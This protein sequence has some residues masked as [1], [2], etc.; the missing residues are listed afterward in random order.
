MSLPLQ[1]TKTLGSATKEA[2]QLPR[3]MRPPQEHLG[4]G[5]S[6]VCF[7]AALQP[8]PL[9]IQTLRSTFCSSGRGPGAASSSWS[10]LHR[11]Q[12]PDRAPGTRWRRRFPPAP[13]GGAALTRMGIDRQVCAATAGASPST[14]PTRAAA[15][16]VLKP[17]GPSSPQGS[18]LALGLRARPLGPC[19]PPLLL[20]PG[21]LLWSHQLPQGLIFSGGGDP[22]SGRSGQSG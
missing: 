4:L 11:T 17:P 12:D 14:P 20:V 19:P 6:L 15:I 2:Q 7:P 5:Q 9:R 3:S 21:Q 22:A 8:L 13:L 18:R 10:H 16:R 1:N